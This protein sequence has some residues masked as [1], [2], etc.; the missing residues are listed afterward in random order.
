MDGGGS[1]DYSLVGVSH[2]HMSM[3]DVRGNAS[4]RNELEAVGY[5]TD[6]LS[7]GTY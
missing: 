4:E 6:T 5:C 7:E 2:P 1:S 3:C